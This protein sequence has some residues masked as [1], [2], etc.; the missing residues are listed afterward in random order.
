VV[1]DPLTSSPWSLLD[2]SKYC[3]VA[4]QEEAERQASM[5]NEARGFTGALAGT[6]ASVAVHEVP[7]PVSNS[8][9]EFPDESM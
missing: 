1:P 4:T 6:G 7:D 9:C 8:P 5:V 2:E 3:P